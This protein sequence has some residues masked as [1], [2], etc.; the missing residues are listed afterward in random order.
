MSTTAE[1]AESWARVAEGW[2]RQ[3]EHVSAVGAPVT[4]RLVELLDPH[5]GE[6]ILEL[7]CGT[8]DVGLAVAPL[9]GDG[10]VIQSDLVPQMVASSRRA[11]E[12]QGVT[13]IEHRVLDAADLALESESVDGVVCRWGYMLLPDPVVGLAETC[14]VLR[15]G[16]RVALA[17]WAEADRNPWAT[18]VGRALVA[19]ELTEPPDPDTPGPFRLGDRSRLLEVVRAAGLEPSLDEEVAVEW[20]APSF[21]EYWRTSLDLSST[22]REWTERLSAPQLAEVRTHVE[23][24]LA[25]FAAPDGIALPGVTR[26]VLAR[27]PSE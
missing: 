11:A 3:R 27:R 2:E 24:T 25:G 12:R 26:V 5:V 21:D 13:S 19:L 6:T 9:V 7:A 23:D 20:R 22:L 14:R 8:G 1:S 18:A 16:G 17:V 10:R 15:P 4:A